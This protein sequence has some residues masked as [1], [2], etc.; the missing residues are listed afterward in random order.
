M[1]LLAPTLVAA[2]GCSVSETK[3]SSPAPFSPSESHLS[4]NPWSHHLTDTYQEREATCTPLH[5]DSITETTLPL[6][7]PYLALL[8]KAM[9]GPQNEEEEESGSASQSLSCHSSRRYQI[10]LPKAFKTESSVPV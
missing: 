7:A 5:Q 6:L 8:V 1:S 10:C 4:P 9:W 3:H 2:S